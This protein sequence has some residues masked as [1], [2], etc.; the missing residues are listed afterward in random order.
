MVVRLAKRGP[1]LQE[2]RFFFSNKKERRILENARDFFGDAYTLF[3]EGLG[4]KIRT[5]KRYSSQNFN[6]ILSGKI[7]V[8]TE[9]WKK[10]QEY[11]ARYETGERYD[12]NTIIVIKV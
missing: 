10:V 7:S 5:K 11:S 12:N 1:F 8:S 9:E 4:R 2:G 3:T 6:K